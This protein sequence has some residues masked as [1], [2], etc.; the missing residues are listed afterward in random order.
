[1]SY[2]SIVAQM[3]LFY[4]TTELFVRSTPIGQLTVH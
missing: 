1:M 3:Q 2:H 4:G